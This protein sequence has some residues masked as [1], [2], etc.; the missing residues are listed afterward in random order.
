MLDF[1]IAVIGLVL[2]TLSMLSL[3]AFFGLPIYEL[4]RRAINND[5]YAKAVYPV[6]A[7][8]P[9]LEAILWLVI[10]LAGGL[11]LVLF[12]RLAPVWLAV[13]LLAVWLWMSYAWLGEM[14]NSGFGRR[15]T[16]LSAVFFG[17]ILQWAYRPGKFLAGFLRSNRTKHTGIYE[18][19]DLYALLL[20]QE[21]QAD[22]RMT[23]LQLGR[24]HKLLVFETANVSHYM[25]AWNQVMSLHADEP[26]GPKLLD[27]MHKSGQT[28]FPVYASQKSKTLVG[29]LNRDD[30]GLKTEGTLADY[31]RTPVRYLSQDESMESAL[32]KFALSGQT[33]FV[34]TAQDRKPVGI[35]TLKDALGSI[36]TPRSKKEAHAGHS[37]E[38]DPLTKDTEL[39]I[40]G[41]EEDAHTQQ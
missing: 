40:E 2:A 10:V 31:M 5:A 17:W 11:A 14:A 28:V 15:I 41:D 23:Q 26:I 39:K 32:A 18:S 21:T 12:D 13:G 30:V 9:V 3:R 29:T 27:D 19:E 6:A 7:Y 34:V 35:L 1:T 22:N 38:L 25:V 8:G 4:K 24:L 16:K 20:K 33:L 36:L 37:D